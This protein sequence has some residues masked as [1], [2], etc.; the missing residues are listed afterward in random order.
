MIFCTH[1]LFLNYIDRNFKKIEISISVT[2]CSTTCAQHWTHEE[3]L[4][5]IND[6]SWNKILK[7]IWS[8]TKINPNRRITHFYHLN[9]GL[10]DDFSRIGGKTVLLFPFLL[11]PLFNKLGAVWLRVIPFC[12]EPFEPTDPFLPVDEYDFSNLV[13]LPVVFPFKTWKWSKDLSGSRS[14]ES[15][16]N[17]PNFDRSLFRH[18]LDLPMKAPWW[19]S[20][21]DLAVS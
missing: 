6:K 19:G 1:S 8:I 5:N 21:V 16:T 2:Y 10:L 7:F 15:S 20:R 18:C 3:Q 12:C 13:L 11:G 14:Q 17:R 4:Q 9:A